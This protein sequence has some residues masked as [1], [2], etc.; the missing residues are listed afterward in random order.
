MRAGRSTGTRLFALAG[1]VNRP[2]VYEVEM[3]HNT[4]RDLVYDPALGG[5]TLDDV[6]VKA[7]I[8]GGVSAPWFGP[9]QVDLPLGQDEVGAAGSM[10]IR[11]RRTAKSCKMRA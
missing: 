6:A 7:F 5:G 3:V 1:R 11:V 2:G 4:F 10:R 9:D 8:P